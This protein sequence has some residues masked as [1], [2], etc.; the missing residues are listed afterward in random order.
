MANSLYSI[1]DGFVKMRCRDYI[2]G[3]IV[4]TCL[5]LAAS[6]VYIWRT[7]V[8]RSVRRLRATVIGFA[9]QNS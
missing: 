7:V 9:K 2:V 4:V 1:G 8:R 6:W 5:V 3:A